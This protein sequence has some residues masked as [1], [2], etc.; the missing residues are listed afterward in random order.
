[1]GNVFL[2]I[3]SAKSRRPK[4]KIKTMLECIKKA[5]LYAILDL[6]APIVNIEKNQ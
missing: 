1:M 3:F 5:V 2:P 4:I 6:V